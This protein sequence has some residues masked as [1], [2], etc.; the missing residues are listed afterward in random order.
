MHQDLYMRQRDIQL[1]CDVNPSVPMQMARKFGIPVVRCG[2]TPMFYKA[3]GEKLIKLIQN[4]LAERSKTLAG[5]Y[6]ASALKGELS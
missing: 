4:Y 3:D 2:G 5:Q 1:A 6:E